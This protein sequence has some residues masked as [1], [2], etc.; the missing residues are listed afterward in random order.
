MKTPY[1]SIK[2]EEWNKKGT[3]QKSLY[4]KIVLYPQRKRKKKLSNRS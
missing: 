2:K 3:F 4:P 1:L